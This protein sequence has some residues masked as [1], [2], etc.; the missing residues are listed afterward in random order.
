MSKILSVKQQN[1]LNGNLYYQSHMDNTEQAIHYVK[2]GAQIDF[3]HEQ[4][5]LNCAE[6]GNTRTFL[7][8]LAYHQVKN[9]HVLLK[10]VEQDNH[11]LLHHLITHFIW[12]SQLEQIYKKHS[13]GDIILSQETIRLLEKLRLV[14][15]LMNKDDSGDEMIQLNKL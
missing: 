12:S 8:L 6:Q 2:A 15:T 13:K 1:T 4:V 11:V 9:E 3:N 10:V 5:F 7:A 14:D